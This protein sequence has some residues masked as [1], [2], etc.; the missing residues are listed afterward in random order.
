M[1]YVP[2]SWSEGNVPRGYG[3]T[4][5]DFY[6]ALWEEVSNGTSGHMNPAIGTQYTVYNVVFTVTAV[7]PQQFI[8]LQ[9]DDGNAVEVP[10]TRWSP[11]L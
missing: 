6:S 9:D 3:Y 10:G 1:T 4:N 5:S 2:W 11:Y 7:E 8:R